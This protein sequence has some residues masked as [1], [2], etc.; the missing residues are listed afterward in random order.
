MI[1]SNNLKKKRKAYFKELHVLLY[2]GEDHEESL[3]VAGIWAEIQTR[4]LS[5]M[6]PPTHSLFDP[7]ILQS[8][9][10]P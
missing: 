10:S 4:D 3:T 6:K 5:Y 1:M 8:L 9:H 2:V 7:I